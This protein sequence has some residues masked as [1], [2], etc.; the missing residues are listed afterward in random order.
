MPCAICN[1]VL[2]VHHTVDLRRPYVIVQPLTHDYQVPG[3]LAP[4]RRRH[5]RLR[6][7]TFKFI[8][9]LSNF[10][11]YVKG[12]LRTFEA[13]QRKEERDGF[14]LEVSA[15]DYHFHYHPSTYCR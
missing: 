11:S 1:L 2:R 6:A 15:T 9:Y 8:S 14:T 5:L 12:Q 7:P 10:F 3:P 4:A 13:R